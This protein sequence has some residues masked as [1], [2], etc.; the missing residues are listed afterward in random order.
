MRIVLVEDNLFQEEAIRNAIRDA[1]PGVS[2]DTIWTELEFRNKLEALVENPPDLVIL[3]VM[4]PWTEAGPE[5]DDFPLEFDD[6]LAGLRCRALLKE[7]AP[8]VPVV[9][10]SI[11][12]TDDIGELAPQDVCFI[13]K[14]SSFE[15]LLQQIG[16]KL[17]AP[18][19]DD[20]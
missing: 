12:H 5:V 13:Q 4:L 8:H 20:G 2:V 19:R 3:D 16:K 14:K 15:K 10:Y 1:F 9:F 18:R 6:R 17:N 11:L 7:R